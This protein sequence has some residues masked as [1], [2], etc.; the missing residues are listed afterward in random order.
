MDALKTFNSLMGELDYPMFIVTTC[1][2]GERSGCL[3]G[4]ATQ[5]SIK[6]PRF[7]VGLSH[8]N[9]TYRVAQR[10]ELL[11]VHFVPADG[12]DL[13]ELFGGE[14]G[15]EIDK[16]ERCE[17][18]PGPG[19]VPIVER[20]PN[21]FVGRVLTRLNAGDH[22]ALILEPVAAGREAEERELT[23]HRARRIEPGHAP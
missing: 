8:K 3:I 10:A 19:G 21:W 4:F 22:D 13:A 12:A 9:H 16:F 23:F 20:C 2:D 17:W 5:I 11:G 15:D 1:V 18:H 14:T 7:L 6:P